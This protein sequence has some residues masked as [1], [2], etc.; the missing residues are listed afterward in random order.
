MRA[1]DRDRARCKN[2]LPS[3]QSPGLQVLQPAERVSPKRARR[4]GVFPH[5]D[6]LLGE[7][8]LLKNTKKRT[9]ASSLEHAKPLRENLRGIYILK[10]Q[11]AGIRVKKMREIQDKNE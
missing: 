8:L 2:Q 10:E 7:S 11:F 4:I 9:S 5:P 1:T 3:E 6:V